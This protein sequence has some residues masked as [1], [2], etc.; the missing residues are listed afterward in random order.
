MFYTKIHIS[1]KE[2]SLISYFQKKIITLRI[3]IEMIENGQKI[4][5]I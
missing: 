5:G 3:L 4:S 1:F 2:L